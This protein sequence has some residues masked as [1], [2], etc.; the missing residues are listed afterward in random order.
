MK[1][2]LTKLYGNHF[3]NLDMLPD[4]AV[5]IDA[6]AC[7]GGFI[8][9]ISSHVKNPQI[10]AIEPNENHKNRISMLAQFP[11]MAALVGEKEPPEMLFYE[12]DNLPEWGNVTNLYSSKKGKTYKV[13]TIS[14]G[15][16]LSTYII[17]EKIHYL[18]MDIE[19]SEW[20]VVKDMNKDTAGRIEQIS[21]EI[22]SHGIDIA[23]KLESL[24]YKT[25]LESGELYAVR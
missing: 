10:W 24:G 7:V 8:E 13:R 11:I 20:D 17:H 4:D 14:L 12:K 15:N 9:D 25:F 23:N 19:G 6:G 22:H 21:M 2:S 16:L 1:D 5:I 3:I 18:K